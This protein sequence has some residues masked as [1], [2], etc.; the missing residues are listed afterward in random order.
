[1]F[2]STIRGKRVGKRKEGRKEGRK[3]EN[4]RRDEKRGC[5]L[6]TRRIFLRY[7]VICDTSFA[8]SIR[9]VLI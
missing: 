3:E 7:N 8:A 1:M 6:K 4:K 2:I 9:A 5:R